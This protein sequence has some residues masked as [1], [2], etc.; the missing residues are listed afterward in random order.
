MTNK[1]TKIE[2]PYFLPLKGGLKMLRTEEIDRIFCWPPGHAEKLARK[3]KLPHILLPDG[4]IRFELK[5]I[6]GLL[7]RVPAAPVAGKEG[8]A[9]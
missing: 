7:R 3:G 4:S 1:K 6:K 5:V 8:A 2:Y 9:K